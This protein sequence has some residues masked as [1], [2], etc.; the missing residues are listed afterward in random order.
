MVWCVGI[1]LSAFVTT[2]APNSKDFFRAKLPIDQRYDQI[3]M[4]K[5][6]KKIDFIL[7]TYP[8]G[9]TSNNLLLK[10]KMRRIRDP[11]PISVLSFTYK[12]LNP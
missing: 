8:G 2:K 1:N 5:T 10:Q 12:Y 4:L 3:L 11:T 9:S 6:P 7:F